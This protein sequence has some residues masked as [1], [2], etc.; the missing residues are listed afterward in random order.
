MQ[1]ERKQRLGKNGTPDAGGGQDSSERRREQGKVACEN[2][3][4]VDGRWDSSL[5]MAF[6]NPKLPSH[7]H[8]MG[9]GPEAECL[10]GNMRP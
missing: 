8:E 4:K 6:C 1:T 10:L 7:A 2:C 9:F 5:T 3:R